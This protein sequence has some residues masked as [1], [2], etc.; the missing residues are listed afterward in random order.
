MKTIIIGVA[1]LVI[2]FSHTSTAQPSEKEMQ[3]WRQRMEQRKKIEDQQEA[4]AKKLMEQKDRERMQQL[5]ANTLSKP[6]TEYGDWNHKPSKE[7]LAH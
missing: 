2:S 4:R 6:K 5:E 3:A 1:V 7:V